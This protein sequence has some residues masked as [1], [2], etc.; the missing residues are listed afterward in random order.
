MLLVNCG[1]VTTVIL[2]PAATDSNLL[3]TATM[4]L[5]EL[6]EVLLELLLEVPLVAP[7]PVP[8]ARLTPRRLQKDQATLVVP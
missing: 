2:R 4:L 3:V 1:L 7:L 8:T 5:V 6:P